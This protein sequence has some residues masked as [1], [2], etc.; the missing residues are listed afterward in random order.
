MSNAVDELV[1]GR[2]SA[3]EF[4][5][6]MQASLIDGHAQ[7]WTLGRQRAGDLTAATADDFFVGLARAD[8]DADFLLSFL[9]DIEGD[10]YRDADGNLKPKAVKARAKLYAQKMRGTSGDAF[11]AA[12]ADEDEFT[13]V[14]A[15]IEHC[16]DCPELAALSPWT[17]DTLFAKP[18]DGETDCLGNCKC[19]LERS[20]DGRQSFKPVSL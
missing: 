9:E 3:R 19:H 2:I 15:G 16:S 5:E 7:S 4:G 13:W 18:G 11:V 17:K 12:C 6:R 20:S 14:M 1:S 10:R 8:A